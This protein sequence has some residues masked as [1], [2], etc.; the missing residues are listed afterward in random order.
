MESQRV[1]FGKFFRGTWKNKNEFAS[2]LADE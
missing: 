1:I 2:L